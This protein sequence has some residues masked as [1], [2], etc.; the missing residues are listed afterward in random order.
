MTEHTH[1]HMDTHEYRHTLKQTYSLRHTLWSI[2]IFAFTHTSLQIHSRA[3][4]HAGLFTHSTLGAKNAQLYNSLSA[5]RHLAPR[6][7]DPSLCKVSVTST[8]PQSFTSTIK[9]SNGESQAD[10][11]GGGLII[12]RIVE[13]RSLASSKELSL[14]TRHTGS[15]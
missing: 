13:S 1:I 14:E 10:N 5:C 9:A 7:C 3:R 2:N 4:I 15:A 6:A 12:K 11:G 8:G